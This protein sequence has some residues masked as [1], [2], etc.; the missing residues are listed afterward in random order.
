MIKNLLRNIFLVVF[1]I[2]AVTLNAQDDELPSDSY[3]KENIAVNEIDAASTILRH[4]GGN[5]DDLNPGGWGDAEGPFVG[6]PVGDAVLPLLT[7]LL[8]YAAFIAYRRKTAK[9]KN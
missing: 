4:S 7:A 3:Y 9:A 6:A 1:F 5:D 8:G 2:M